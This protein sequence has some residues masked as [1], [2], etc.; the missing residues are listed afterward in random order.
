MN[1]HQQ[2]P[3][4]HWPLIITLE[5]VLSDS[6][7]KPFT[8]MSPFFIQNPIQRILGTLKS[9]KNLKS[10]ALLIEVTKKNIVHFC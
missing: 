9:V 8:K 7:P 2:H 4:E 5:A 1:K 3:A 10:G 6:L